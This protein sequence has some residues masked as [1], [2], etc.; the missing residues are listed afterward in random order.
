MKRCAL[1][2]AMLGTKGIPAKWGGIEK[3]VQEISTRL[4]RKGHEVSVY[5]SRWFLRDYNRSM[6]EGVKIMRVPAIKWQ[7]T[8]ALTNG[9]Y[10]IISLLTKDCDIA[11]FHGYASYFFLPLLRCI[12]IKTVITAHGFESGWDNPKYGRYARYVIKKGYKTGVKQGERITSVAK[13]V[14]NKIKA[15]YGIDAEVISS[16]LDPPKYRAPKIIRVQ[17]GL[18]GGDYALFLGRIDPI[19]RIDWIVD[20]TKTVAHLKTVVIAGGAQNKETE[21]YYSWLKEQAEQTRARIVFTGSV[22]GELKYELLSNCRIFLAPSLDEGL[23]IAL[24][25]AMS[26][27]RVCIASDIAGHREVIENAVSGYLFQSNDKT[28]FSEILLN[29]HKRPASELSA[30]ASRARQVVDE[31]YSWDHAAARFEGIYTELS[32]KK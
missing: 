1:K 16:G 18:N 28:Q 8:D 22:E 11:H 9:L 24:L 31:N 12:G 5:G 32:G 21:T 20:A 17:Y 10:S 7:A 25:E 15:H 6:Y 13:H 30:V 27:G 19:K 29:V 26:Y 4:A 14:S 23:P 2:I 3:Y